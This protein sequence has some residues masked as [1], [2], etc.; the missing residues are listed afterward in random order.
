MCATALAMRI[1]AQAQAIDS[2]RASAEHPPSVAAATYRATGEQGHEKK[3]KYTCLMHP[4][5]ISDH[6]GNCPKCGMKLV[7]I[8][9]SKRS[10]SNAQRPTR[11]RGATARQASN[12]QS[13]EMHEHPP[14]V[15][16]HEMQMEM[17]SSIDVADPMSREGSGTSWLPDSSPMYGRMF[18]F[19][20]DMLMLHGAIFPRYTNVSTRRGDDRID[21]P[22]WI[23]AMY[24]HALGDATQIGARLMMSLDPL[25]EG[26]RGYPLLFQS[27]ESWNGEPLHDRQHPHDLFDELSLSLSQKFDHDFSGYVYF[28]YPGEPALGPPTFMHRPSAMD[29]PDAPIG[30]HWQDST[31][32][33][34]GVA[35]AGIAWNNVKIEG[36][37][38]TGREPDE[39]RY[40]FD[41]PK[42]DSY[43]GRISWNPTRNLALQVSYGY[44]HS[45]E[46]LEP[47]LNRHR[48]TA[49]VIYNL[50]LG[51]DSNWS[52]TFVWGQNHD[53]AG[54]GKTQS[55]LVESNYQRGPNTVYFRWERVE[56]S[57]EELVLNAAADTRIFPVGAYTL[58]YVRDLT[59]GD[60]L[61]IG[62]GTQFTINNRPDALDRYYGEDL[63]YAFQFFLRIRPSL[64]SHGT[65]EHAEHVA[66]MEK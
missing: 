9:G 61:D 13:H 23:M 3:Q 18:M 11:L 5:V 19:G 56:K 36:S 33:T 44:I 63:G 34:F 54:Q 39:D 49:S 52:N 4:E 10:T 14:S 62:L 53:T 57:G 17:H 47:E 15:A 38:F 27:G 66:G 24:S 8:N 30:H 21:A 29:D 35:T 42:F 6:P 12:H 26:G 7:P 48:T 16:G 58:G 43:S 59:H 46:A 25:T 37:I 20:D 60:G 65:H 22:N 28:G 50:P 40:N 41:Q 31:H 64:H 2:D 51:N 45:P 55:F 32:V 1:S